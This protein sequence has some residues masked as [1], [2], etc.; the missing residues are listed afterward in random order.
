MKNF[1]IGAD[2]LGRE[3]SFRMLNGTKFEVDHNSLY[4]WYGNNPDDTS[5]NEDCV[6]IWTTY[7]GIN[8]MP[9]TW[10]YNAGNDGKD[11]HG[12]CEIPLYNCK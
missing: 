5:G 6:H 8:D 3:G 1:W 12:L 2:D 9:C 10:V 7:D 4:G 11:F